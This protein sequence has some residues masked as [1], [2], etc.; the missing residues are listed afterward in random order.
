M[1]PA[2]LALAAALVIGGAV[3][4]AAAAST[5]RPE[6]ISAS[7]IGPASPAVPAQATTAPS[8]ITTSVVEEID[9]PASTRTVN[10][11]IAALLILGAV[12][13]AVTIWFWIA[14]KPLHPALEGLEL[15]THRRWARAKP[16]K[17]QRM[18]DRVHRNRG[19]VDERIVPATVTGGAVVAPVPAGRARGDQTPPP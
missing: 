14:T 9:D 5:A 11:V 15:M 18:L 12:L 16:A 10:R 2:A 4:L 13:L 7:P 8:T 1:T 17:R 19:Q 6:A 3:P